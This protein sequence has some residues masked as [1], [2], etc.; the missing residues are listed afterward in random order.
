MHKDFVSYRYRCTRTG[1]FGRLVRNAKS[2]QKR[3]YLKKGLIPPEFSLTLQYLEQ[4]Y[5]KQNEKGFYSNIPI[6][7][8]PL[9]DWQASLERLD[10]GQDYI[11][12][13]VV[14]E[15]SEF[16]GRC[17]WS[18]KKVLEIPKL[19]HAPINQTLDELDAAKQGAVD[20]KD[21]KRIYNKSLMRDNR[22]WCYKC[23]TWIQFDGFYAGILT[24]CKQCHKKRDLKGKNT[25]R[26]YFQQMVCS[27]RFNAATKRSG[28]DD[29]RNECN[30]T[31]DDLF[32]ILESQNFRCYYSGIP[33]AFKRNA[34]WRCS[35]ERLDNMC[36]YTIDN[37]VL[38][39]WE[40]NSADRTAI[41]KFPVH[42]SS[43]W[44]KAKFAYFYRTRFGHVELS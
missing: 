42:G 16:N 13:N 9:S 20:R 21:K 19:I 32:G 30:I 24:V 5:A 28:V 39:C 36:G 43:Q 1:Y 18:M 40:F 3:R 37:C 25:L 41:A 33:M 10:P 23:D 27:A 11:G 4:L 12:S 17:Q 38:I 31:L 44:S 7:L 34:D 8:R 14:L 15:A 29:T 26:G 6:I 22:L 35:L 2:T